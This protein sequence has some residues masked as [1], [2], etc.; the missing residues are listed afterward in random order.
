MN[1]VTSAFRLKFII[2]YYFI[3]I[4]VCSVYKCS[5]KIN[6]NVVVNYIYFF[7]FHCNEGI[8]IGRVLI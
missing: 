2:F 7:N 3:L 4:F 8:T 5:I 1:S 6:G